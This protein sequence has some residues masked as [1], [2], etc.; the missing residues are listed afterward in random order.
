MQS[1]FPKSSLVAIAG[2]NGRWVD[3]TRRDRLASLTIS[4]LVLIRGLRCCVIR[5]QNC[6]FLSREAILTNEVLKSQTQTMGYRC[7]KPEEN[8][9]GSRLIETRVDN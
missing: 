9:N 7:R 8:K 6:C 4:A 2:V 3:R 1:L 5:L